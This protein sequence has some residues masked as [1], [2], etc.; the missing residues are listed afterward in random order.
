M[1]LIMERLVVEIGDECAG[2]GNMTP[3]RWNHKRL[4]IMHASTQGILLRNLISAYGLEDQITHFSFFIS[5]QQQRSKLRI[6]FQEAV[7]VAVGFVAA[8]VLLATAR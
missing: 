6:K 8:A 7:P 5:W 4:V 2:Q 1:N 3:N